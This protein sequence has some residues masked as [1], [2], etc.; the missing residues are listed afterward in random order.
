MVHDKLQ[1]DFQTW[2][3]RLQ[4]VTQVCALACM[5]A[6]TCGFVLNCGSGV[7]RQGNS[8]PDEK[9]KAVS[10]LARSFVRS[11]VD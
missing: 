10:S 11:F 6:C 4:D 1:K 8:I 7:D 9:T 2:L 5:H 3:Q